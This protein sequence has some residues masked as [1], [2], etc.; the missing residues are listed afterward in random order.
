MNDTS[1]RLTV[2]DEL[3]ALRSGTLDWRLSRGDLGVLAVLLKHS[4]AAGESWPGPSRIADLAN[5]AV[6]NVKASLRRLEELRYI[7]VTR[8]GPRKKN[9]FTVLTSPAV[10][11]QK[12]AR[13][14]AKCAR[15]LGI[16]AGPVAKPSRA[17]TGP[18]DRTATRPADRPELGMR[19]GHELASELAI[20]LTAKSA[21][22]QA[23][24]GG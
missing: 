3:Q 2:L 20:E 15:E 18:A 1:D 9:R 17:A 12:A 4:N 19:A 13:A 16:R 7:A 14:M 21:R 10:P 23:P 24:R 6:S 8:P 22:M 11:S 5:L